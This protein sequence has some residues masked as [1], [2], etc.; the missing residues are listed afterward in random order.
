[1]WCLEG[2]NRTRRAVAGAEL[3]LLIEIAYRAM[4][5]DL[6]SSLIFSSL[7]EAQPRTSGVPAGPSLL[8]SATAADSCLLSWLY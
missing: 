6:M 4:L 7:R 5:V 3:D 2:I 1:M 8:S